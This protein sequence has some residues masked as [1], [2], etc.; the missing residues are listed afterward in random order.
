MWLLSGT[1]CVALWIASIAPGCR[2]GARCSPGCALRT[3]ELQPR[4]VATACCETVEGEP[5]VHG[6]LYFRAR[7]YDPATGRFVQ[8]D[9]VWD[10]GNFGNQYSFV[11]NSPVSGVDP[12]GDQAQKKQKKKKEAKAVKKRLI[13][14]APTDPRWTKWSKAQ[15]KRSKGTIVA[16]PLEGLDRL[17]K[18]ANANRQKFAEV[19]IVHHGNPQEFDIGRA[20]GGKAEAVDMSLRKG[21]SRDPTRKYRFR[22]W[23][24]LAEALKALLSK[25]ARGV[26]NYACKVLKPQKAREGAQTAGED[27]MRLTSSS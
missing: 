6:L 18:F 23:H 11:G 19:Y 20:P 15:A 17:K 1:I 21:Q 8:R 26:H 22:N 16:Q 9:P 24:E 27:W 7:Y 5:E 13:L 3:L 25:D 10:P 2:G 4:Y 14:Y 12:F